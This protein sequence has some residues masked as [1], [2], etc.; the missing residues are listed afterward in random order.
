[1]LKILKWWKRKRNSK[2]TAENE[3]RVVYLCDGEKESCSK[4]NCYRNGG[5]CKHTPDIKNAKNFTQWH[6]GR[7]WHEKEK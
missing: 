2:K 1:M 7:T 3:Q 4:R 5:D 6:G